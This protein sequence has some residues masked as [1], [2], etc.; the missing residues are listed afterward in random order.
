MGKWKKDTFLESMKYNK[1]LYL[2]YLKSGF[3]P[4]GNAR[5]NPEQSAKYRDLDIRMI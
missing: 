5:Q 1:C 2:Y 3:H 4:L